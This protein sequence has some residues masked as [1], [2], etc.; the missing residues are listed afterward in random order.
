[1][2]GGVRGLQESGAQMWWQ[3]GMKLLLIA[4]FLK[5]KKTKVQA[6]QG[7]IYGELVEYITVHP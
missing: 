2:G 7:F 3:R 1:M 4:L 5:K 6:A